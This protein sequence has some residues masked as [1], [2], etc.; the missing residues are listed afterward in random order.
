MSLL[1][2]N[3][4][5]LFDGEKVIKNTSIYIENGKIVSIAIIFT[6]I[7]AYFALNI[8]AEFDMLD[9]LPE[10]LEITKD[11]NYLLKNFEIAQGKKL[12]F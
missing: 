5:E 9:F 6:I 8:E 2:K 4:G 11:I 10:K 12:L 1:I 7:T 3:I